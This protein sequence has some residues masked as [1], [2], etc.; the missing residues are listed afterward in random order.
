MT[1]RLVQVTAGVLAGHGRVLICQRPVGGLHAG[2]WEFPGGKVEPGESLEEAL[3]R[4]LQEELGI[5]ATIGPA[6]WE[7]H[8]QY[9][10]RE[11]F[12]LTFFLVTAHEGTIVNRVFADMQWVAVSA[13]PEFDFLEGDRA[14]VA[15]LTRGGVLVSARAR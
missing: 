1:N 7:T 9:P 11:P 13:L 3:R 5:E 12:V 2:K 6:L 14:F 4:E 8:Y 15:Q 10:G